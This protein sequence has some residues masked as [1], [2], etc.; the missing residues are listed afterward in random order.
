[1][2]DNRQQLDRE[3]DVALA[4]YAAVEP[5]A[6]LEERI[7]AN[8]RNEQTKVSDHVWWRWAIGIAAAAIVVAFALNSR[9][10]RPSHSMVVAHKPETQM[11]HQ[12]ASVAQARRHAPIRKT[13]AHSARSGTPAAANPKLDHFPSPRPLSEQE[14]ILQNYV[15]KNPERAVLIARA[16]S[17]ALRQD[18]LE[19]MK[20]F[21]GDQAKDSEPPN[22]DTTDR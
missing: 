9:S 2:A 14:K 11:T 8:L 13:I 10:G 22:N 3:L 6:G 20:A 5:R 19:E 4:K 1:M 12:G 21:P 18:H 7:L 17:E 16:V 15:A